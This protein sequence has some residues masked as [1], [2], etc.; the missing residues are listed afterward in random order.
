MW[1]CSW[2]ASCWRFLACIFSG[3]GLVDSCWNTFLRLTCYASPL[4]PGRWVARSIEL[5][6]VLTLPLH[7]SEWQFF[8]FYSL[9]PTCDSNFFLVPRG[10]ITWLMYKL[11][12]INGAYWCIILNKQCSIET[13]S[14]SAS[15][16]ISTC[17]LHH[18]LVRNFW[19]LAH[20]SS[21]FILVNSFSGCNRKPCNSICMFYVLL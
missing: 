9:S 19:I 21:T 7:N 4:D 18:G 1:I 12:Y 10:M 16:M 3:L 15:F 5:P 13:D 17:E 14:P 20:V 8:Q 11:S 2:L 6:E